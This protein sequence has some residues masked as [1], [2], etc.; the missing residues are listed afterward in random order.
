MRL[1]DSIRFTAGHARG[2]ADLRV[3]LQQNRRDGLRPEAAVR[4]GHGAPADASPRRDARPVATKFRD[5]STV[6]RSV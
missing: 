1:I 3:V 5:L 2:Q 4:E 6:R